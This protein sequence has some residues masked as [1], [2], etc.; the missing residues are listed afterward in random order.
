[1]IWR[2]ITLGMYVFI[3]EVVLKQNNIFK[4]FDMG[5]DNLLADFAI[6]SFKY[7]SFLFFQKILLMIYKSLSGRTHL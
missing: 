5:L 7:V 1:M 2:H 6:G 3:Y 4:S